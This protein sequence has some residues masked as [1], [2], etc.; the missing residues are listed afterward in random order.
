[1]GYRMSSVAADWLPEVTAGAEDAIRSKPNDHR[2]GLPEIRVNGRELR[3]VSA[4]A[5]EAVSAANDPAKLFARAGGVV[6]V[7]HDEDGRPEI[8]T[9]TDVHLRG[10][11]TR[12]AN[13]YK[14]AGRIEPVRIA[15]SPPMDAAR[16]ILSRPVTELGL[17]PLE[18]IAEAPFIRPDG[19]IVLKPGYDSATRTFYAPV[20]NIGNVFVP[21]RPTADDVDGARAL[22]EDVLGDFPFADQASRS[23]AFALL[24]TPELRH[25]ISGNVPMCLVDA[26]QAGSGKTLLVSVVSEKTTG[27]TA[28]IKPRLYA[29]TMSGERL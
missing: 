12:A 4:E 16:D 29:T 24:I 3:D 2:T 9:V 22:L 6:R 26:P 21:D 7:D 5:L 18:A 11:M 23:N 20:D 13:F 25:A 15:V 1:M 19:T 10:E 28:A 14:V 17:P 8:V 27:S